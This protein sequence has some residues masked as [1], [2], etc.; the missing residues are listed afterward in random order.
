M[1]VV[2]LPY[3]YRGLVQLTLLAVALPWLAWHFALHD[4]F[5]AWRDYR[6]L[7]ARLETLAPEAA[8]PAAVT[9][10]DRELILS[11][12]L[13]DT[14]RC[15]ASS[16]KAKVTGYEPLVT[17]E[18]DGLSLHTAQLTLA[19]DYASLLQVVDALEKA[20][21]GCRLRSLEWRMATDRRTRWMQLTLTLHIQQI[22]L[23][24]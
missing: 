8:Q 11:G 24:K 9:A 18:Q 1:F 21:P 13:L 6:R 4:T 19:G 2:R 3:K 16:L 17:T 5:A 15:A 22:V 7:A 20:L 12:G 14:V 10:D 23:K